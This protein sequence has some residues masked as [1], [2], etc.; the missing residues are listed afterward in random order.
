MKT[1]I[2]I[3]LVATASLALSSTSIFAQGKGNPAPKPP[4]EKTAPKGDIGK[5][6]DR[7]VD[8]N[9]DRDFR[10]GEAKGH[11]IR[12]HDTH[13]AKGHGEH[14]NGRDCHH[15]GRC[16]H[17]HAVHHVAP[18]PPHCKPVP[19]PVPAP[20]PAPAPHHETGLVFDVNTGTFAIHVSL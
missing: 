10:K 6:S 18:A 11:D 20:R 9:F 12:R 7:K 14:R 8:K 19:V 16:H 15:E 17:Q 1:N 5:K 2:I 13:M 3:A 4:T